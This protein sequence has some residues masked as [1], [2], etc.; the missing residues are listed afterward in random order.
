VENIHT[1][2]YGSDKNGKC[3]NVFISESRFIA[4]STFKYHSFSKFIYRNF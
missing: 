3:Y 4:K 2:N 1:K